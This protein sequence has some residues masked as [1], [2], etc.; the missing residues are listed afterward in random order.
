MLR[1]VVHK[2]GLCLSQMLVADLRL[3]NA[4]LDAHAFLRAAEVCAAESGQTRKGIAAYYHTDDVKAKF[5]VHTDNTYS[6]TTYKSQNDPKPL[7]CISTAAE[8]KA[9]FEHTL[10]PTAS[11]YVNEIPKM[12]KGKQVGTLVKLLYDTYVLIFVIN[13]A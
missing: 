13:F 1:T 11:Y 12:E 4:K 6:N 7:P 8:V 10:H 5:T 2:L 9:F 3:L